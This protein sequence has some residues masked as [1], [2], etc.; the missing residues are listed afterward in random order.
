VGSV[1]SSQSAPH[2]SVSSGHRVPRDATRS[3]GRMALRRSSSAPRHTVGG[4]VGARVHLEATGARGATD[5]S[6]SGPKRS[7][8][9]P[10]LVL[11]RRDDASRGAREA[12]GLCRSTLPRVRVAGSARIAL[13]TRIGRHVAP[14][15][16]R[17][18]RT[19]RRSISLDSGR[20]RQGSRAPYRPHRGGIRG[21]SLW[22]ERHHAATR[23]VP[24]TRAGYRCRAPREWLSAQ[25][26]RFRALSHSRRATG[27]RGG[28]AGPA[29]E[30]TT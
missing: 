23:V 15:R 6:N 11:G 14:A 9:A 16:W 5:T 27:D 22:L 10:R 28:G 4:V 30:T 1:A 25:I 2:T 17:G 13:P 20:A 18:G 26:L 29:C 3:A 24:R 8:E 19:G 21:P 7:R 12:R